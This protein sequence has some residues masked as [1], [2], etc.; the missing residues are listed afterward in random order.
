MTLSTPA[1]EQPT[2]GASGRA[3]ALAPPEVPKVPE[4]KEGEKRMKVRPLLPYAHPIIAERREAFP[5]L[6]ASAFP[7]A[8]RFP[9]SAFPIKK[10]NHLTAD[11]LTGDG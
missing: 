8:Q 10:R 4:V 1:Q 3:K 6:T 11:R 5:D 2:R 7:T 9:Y